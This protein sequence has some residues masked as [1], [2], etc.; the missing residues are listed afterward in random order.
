MKPITI[1]ELQEVE[2]FIKVPNEF[3]SWDED[4]QEQYILQNCNFLDPD[5]T[6]I[7]E[8]SWYDK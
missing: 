5:H 7:V 8:R 3:D 4:K 6:K 2:F 1:S